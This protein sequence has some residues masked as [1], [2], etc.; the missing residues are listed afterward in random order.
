MKIR[1]KI[2]CLM[3][4]CILGSLFGD[5]NFS[6]A[7]QAGDINELQDQIDVKKAQIDQINDKI[8]EYRTRINQYSNQAASLMG[9]VE[10]IENQI[11]L[12][13]LDIQST[14]IEIESQQMEV[15]LL[16]QAIEEQESKIVRQREI[17]E[18]M[19][20]ELNKND[21]IGF[22]E[23]LFGAGDFN[24]LFMA[25]KDLETVNAD[26]QNALNETK[27]TKESLGADKIEQ[28]EK[29]ENLVALQE[30]LKNQIEQ[31]EHQVGAKSV[32]IAQTQDSESEYRV[33]MSELRQEQQYISNQINTLQSEMSGKLDDLDELGDSTLI[34]WPT[35]GIITAI[36]HDPSYP[37]RHLFEHGGLDIAVPTGT[38]IEAAAPGYVAWAR[39]GASYGNYVMIIHANGYATLY[40]HLSSFNVSADQFVSRGQV[41]GYS[42]STGLSTG[43]HLHFE[44]RVNGIP[45]NPQSYLVD[46]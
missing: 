26:L 32:L 3:L 8:D 34:S 5:N 11:A 27:A 25:V 43:P 46:Y 16:E 1:S 4:L 36:F 18:N 40:A 38:P 20:F 21:G 31:M 24:E 30:S 19:I 15:Q 12:A 14:E 39:T 23:V 13:Q 33:L 7:Q 10:M 2:A 35:H 44:V 45:V 41:I 28:E 9:D 6:L 37:F 22:V 42:G 29:L 17:L